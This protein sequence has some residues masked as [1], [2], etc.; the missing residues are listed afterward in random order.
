MKNYFKKKLFLYSIRLFDVSESF[1]SV[2]NGWC[3]NGI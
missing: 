1:Y 3:R 2:G